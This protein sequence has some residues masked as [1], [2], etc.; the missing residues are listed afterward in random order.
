[1]WVIISEIY[2]LRAR[3]KAMAVATMFNWIFL[4]SILA[5]LYTIW[6][7]PE[8][9]NRSLDEIE[10]EVLGTEPPEGPEEQRQAA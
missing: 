7:V 1:M 10:M 9:K 6:K 2:P 8:T 3:S 4:I 5:L